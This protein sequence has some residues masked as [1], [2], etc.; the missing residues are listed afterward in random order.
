MNKPGHSTSYPG[1]SLV[2][3]T[4]A[5]GIV[6]FGLIAILGLLPRGLGLVRES[7]AEATAIN[8]MGTVALDLKASGITLSTNTPVELFFDTDGLPVES[9]GGGGSG[10]VARV[11]VR[12]NAK[13]WLANIQVLW[14]QANPVNSVETLVVV[15]EAPQ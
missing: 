10:Y 7:A 11:Q 1:F 14:P 8:V 13:P 15:P 6:A 4:L 3:V 5:L 9:P 2:E 12:G